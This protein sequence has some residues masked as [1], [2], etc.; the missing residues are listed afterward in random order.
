MGVVYVLL[1]AN[2]SGAR[3]GTFNL[4]QQRVRDTVLLGRFHYRLA[5]VTGRDMTGNSVGREP[6]QFR[7][8]TR[9]SGQITRGKYFHDFYVHPHKLTSPVFDT[10]RCHNQIPAR[11][12]DWPTGRAQKRERANLMAADDN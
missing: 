3:A 1:T 2:S 10:P 7:G 12:S 9:S 4:R 6:H 11:G 8:S 5:R